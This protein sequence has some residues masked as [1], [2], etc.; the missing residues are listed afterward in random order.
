MAAAFFGFVDGEEYIGGVTM[1]EMRQA[2][3]E[4]V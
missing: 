4:H 1:V 2:R 3:E